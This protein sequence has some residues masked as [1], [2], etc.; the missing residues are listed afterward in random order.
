M[1]MRWWCCRLVA[2]VS[3]AGCVTTT[4]KIFLPSPANPRYTP[5]G[6]PAVLAEYVRLQCSTIKQAQRPDTGSVDFRIAVD[7]LGHVTSAELLKSSG[8]EALDGVFGAMAA[9]LQVAPASG[10]RPPTRARMIYDCARQPAAVA[11]LT[12][13]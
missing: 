1:A 7:S 9:Q 3:I 10:T 13:P 4:T 2:I 11:V 6:A 8:D 5:E 12:Q